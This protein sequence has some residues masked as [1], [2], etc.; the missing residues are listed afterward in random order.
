MPWDSIAEGITNWVKGILIDA[1]ESSL[2]NLFSSVN[3]QVGTAAAT[4]GQSPSEALGGGV[5]PLI[6]SISETVIMPVAG[7]ILTFVACYEL[8]QLVTERNNLANL[9]TWIFFKWVLKTAIAVLLIT[10][11]FNIVLAVFD[12]SQYVVQQSA[13]VI[14][15][16]ASIT[17]ADMSALDATLQTMDIGPLLGMLVTAQLMQLIMPIISV[18]I[19]VIVYAR[20][21]QIY[22][23]VSLAPVPMATFGNKEIAHIGKNFFRSL[24]ALAFQGFLMMV[25]IGIY[26]IMLKNMT[27]S[28]DVIGYAWGVIGCSF[29]LIVTLIETGSI[30]KSIFDA[31]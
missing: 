28:S 6:Q 3:T 5:L 14:S 30:S 18:V 10:N 29:L 20:L 2:S 15:T 25:C 23:M 7:I 27:V 8:I 16:E 13:G 11:T 21:I 31:H 12:V 17:E 24:L 9:D 4:I 19:T 22:L 1:I 26:A